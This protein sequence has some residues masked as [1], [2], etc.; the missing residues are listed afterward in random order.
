[1][2]QPP[3]KVLLVEDSPVALN[4]LQRLLKSCP[5]IAVVGT[6]SNGKEALGLIPKLNPEVICTD[7][8][9]KGMDGLELTQQVMAKYP[10]P[11]LV[12][13]N[14][15]QKYDTKN[16]FKLLQAGALDVFPKPKT[17]RESD[18][19]KV[20]EQLLDKIKVIS[21]VSVFT[22]PLRQT[23]ASSINT[24]LSSTQ[25]VSTSQAIKKISEQEKGNTIAY[26]K[27][28]QDIAPFPVKV[29]AIGVSTGGPRALNQVISPLPKN[30]PVPIICT[31]HISPGFLEGLVNWLDGESQ[32][33]IKIA[34]KG[35]Y[36]RPG[37]VY[38]APENSHLQLTSQGQF[39]H[40][41]TEP[42]D[43]HCPSATVMFQSVAKFYGRKS[44]GILLT[45]MGR[46]GATGMKAIA[47]IGGMTIAQD[48]KSCIVFGMPK[49]AIEIGAAKHILP[50][51]KIAPLL[52]K[53]QRP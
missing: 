31:Q 39:I 5:E 28:T 48:E 7:F 53:I 36:P 30:F 25:T 38:F 18:Y 14:S 24:K 22:K 2:S 11:I 43:G 16:V 19:G 10:R 6:A 41:S 15:V 3:I 1:M 26:L 32:L 27:A 37:T 29:V 23:V 40:T 52:T 20:K 47:E 35:E 44:L 51:Q 9:M 12:I 46:D 49:A 45:G 50:L 34:Q 8:T 33:R 17:G 42:V 4:I 21:G 13:S